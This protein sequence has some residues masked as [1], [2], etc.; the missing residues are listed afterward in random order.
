MEITHKHDEGM[1]VYLLPLCVVKIGS[2]ALFLA[3]ENC[4]IQVWVF[5]EASRVAASVGE[6]A[7]NR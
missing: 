5:F 3:I 7:L 4:E 2:V 6:I 1:L